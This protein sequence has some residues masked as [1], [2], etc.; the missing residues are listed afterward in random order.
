MGFLLGALALRILANPLGN[1][2]QKQLVQKG[3]GAL[4][5][6]FCTYALLGAGSAFF[7]SNIQW[8]TFSYNLWLVAAM[9]GAL[10]AIGNACLIKALKTGDLSVLGPVNAYKSVAALVF[11]VILLGELPPAAAFVGIGLILAGSY[12]TLGTLPEKFTPR[13]LLR[14]DIQFRL[15]ALVLTAAEAVLI[16]K[17]I[18]LSTVG[19]AFALWCWFGALF[20]GGLLL[21]SGRGA[22]MAQI[23]AEGPRYAA[24][25]G[26]MGLMQLSTN[27]VFARMPVAPAL[28]LFQLSLLV[29]VL[30]GCKY[31][32]EPAF[33]RRLLGAAVMLA[34]SVLIIFAGRGV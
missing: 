29:S 18:L 22:A 33:G 26:L 15:L 7:S 13:V 11:G 2:V 30:F 21:L 3:H 28:A 24:L 1:V 5:V 34:G 16:K 14:T 9:G 19:A 4:T 32:K 6:N 17:V 20:A 25:A 31:F 8:R 27:Y 23:A 10:G 12:Y